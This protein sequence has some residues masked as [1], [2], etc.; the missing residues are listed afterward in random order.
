[1]GRLP[2]AEGR[3][4]ACRHQGCHVSQV[5]DAIGSGGVS[6]AERSVSLS[7]PD[8]KSSSMPVSHAAS[9]LCIG[10]G[11]RFSRFRSPAAASWT[12]HVCSPFRSF[13]RSVSL[14]TGYFLRLCPVC[15]GPPLLVRWRSSTGLGTK[16]DTLSEALA[17]LSP[18]PS[19]SGWG[20]HGQHVTMLPVSSYLTISTL[21]QHK[22][23]RRYVSVALSLK[24]PSLTLYVTALR[25]ATYR[26]GLGLRAHCQPGTGQQS[27]DSVRSPTLGFSADDAGNLAVL[28]SAFL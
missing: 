12:L 5:R 8:W 17:S 21:P 14:A 27:R 22:A 18:A 25:P 2:P 28:S 20:L 1:L 6:T 7:V 11:D 16:A 19:C 23:D 24:S 13:P 10:A 15:S 3:L 26:S 9:S 4:S